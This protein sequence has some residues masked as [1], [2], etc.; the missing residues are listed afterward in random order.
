ME[1]DEQEQPTFRDEGST[2]EKVQGEDI[3]GL[4]AEFELA[5]DVSP[6]PASA[7]RP[8][9]TQRKASP[10]RVSAVA[11]GSVVKVFVVKA[12]V[13]Y[14]MPWQRKAPKNSSG[15]GFTIHPRRILTNAHVIE[16]ST[17]IM[18]VPPPP[19]LISPVHSLFGLTA[20]LVKGKA[21]RQTEALRGTS[22]MRRAPVRHRPARGGRRG[23][24]GWL[25]PAQ[26]RR[27]A[28]APG[29]G[30]LRRLPNRRRQHLR[31]LRRRLSVCPLK[32]I[33][34]QVLI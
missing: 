34:P 24:L 7:E 25:H 23:L 30:H 3:E 14:K 8:K 13:S 4:K 16:D 22:G 27:R 33:I 6:S 5:D 20:F 32:Q 26:L 29:V 2:K 10:G 21:A 31:H 18:F 28:P 11:M 9:K 12:K 1:D 17:T 19:R 15:S